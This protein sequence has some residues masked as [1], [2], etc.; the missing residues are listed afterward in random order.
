[1][2]SQRQRGHFQLGGALGQ[3]RDAARAIEQAVLGMDVEMNETRRGHDP[4][5]SRILRTASATCRNGEKTSAAEPIFL[6]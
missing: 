3:L 2:I 4:N 6:M 1:V 5:L